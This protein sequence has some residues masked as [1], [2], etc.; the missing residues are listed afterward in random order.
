MKN[1]T[2]FSGSV[3]SPPPGVKGYAPPSCPPPTTTTT[4]TQAPCP[5]RT[6]PAASKGYP[7]PQVTT[8]AASKGYPQPSNRRS[9]SSV[10][11]GGRMRLYQA[12]QTSGRRQDQ[13]NAPRN[14][15]SSYNA[16]IR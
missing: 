4:T 12:L 6:T 14:F 9:Q 8:P 13:Y 16:P 5:H 10:S 11:E 3:P 2:I 1:N 15:Q 7:Q